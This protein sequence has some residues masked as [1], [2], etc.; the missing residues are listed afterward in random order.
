MP[1]A[2]WTACYP[3]FMTRRELTD[4]SL[5]QPRISWEFSRLL[6]T[7][8]VAC[9]LLYLLH[10]RGGW[11]DVWKFLVGSFLVSAASFTTWR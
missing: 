6:A 2:A 3:G 9:G 5:R 7:E 4:E 10:R 1:I 8:A 11:R